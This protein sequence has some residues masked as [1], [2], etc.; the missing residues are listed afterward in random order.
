MVI[1]ENDD[2][3]FPAC[4]MQLHIKMSHVHINNHFIYL[5]SC[6]Q[7]LEDNVDIEVSCSQYFRV[8]DIVGIVS[9]F[10]FDC[11]NLQRV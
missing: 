7:P 10:L 2:L 8:Y 6:T 1:L 11:N 3:R 9:R 4:L 5:V